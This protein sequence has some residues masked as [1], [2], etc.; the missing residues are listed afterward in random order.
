ME[1]AADKDV[2][3]DG[4]VNPED[5]RIA[6]AA[7]YAA[8]HAA[9]ETV[10]RAAEEGSTDTNVLDEFNAE[11]VANLQQQT[12]SV[13]AGETAT[14]TAT[15]AATSTATAGGPQQQEGAP[16]QQEGTPQDEDGLSKDLPRLCQLKTLGERSKA[17][18]RFPRRNCALSTAACQT[19]HLAPRPEAACHLLTIVLRF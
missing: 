11:P 3:G 15:A 14:A 18:V 5:A 2:N 9:Q 4:R 1:D 6:K 10:R 19:A 13:P 16:Q 7:S 12:T 8:S 17:V